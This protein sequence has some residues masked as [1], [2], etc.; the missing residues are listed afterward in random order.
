[1]VVD[2][3]MNLVWCNQAHGA[4]FPGAELI[5]R[6]CYETLGSQEM[7][8]GCPTSVALK[9]GKQVQALYDFGG[10]NSLIV[11]MPLAEGY[12][13]KIMMDVPKTADGK[14]KIVDQDINIR[15]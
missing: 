4:M 13:A 8:K 5:G 7:H 10:E 2:R 1:M 15:S 3:E 11:T 6:K 12:V 14:L 9:T